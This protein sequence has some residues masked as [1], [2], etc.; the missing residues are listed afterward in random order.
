VDDA[1]LVRV[2]EGFGGLD[3]Q[4]GDAAEEVFGALGAHCR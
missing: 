4:L 3:P 1:H 2:V